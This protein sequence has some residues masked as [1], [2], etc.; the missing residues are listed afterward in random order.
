MAN[1]ED[2]TIVL[3]EDDP[4]HAYLIQKNLR[5]ANITNQ[6]VLIEDGQTAVDYL[7]EKNP[8]P[9]AALSPVLMLL[10]LN[11]PVLDGYEV[12]Q[13]IKTDDR[14]RHIPVIILTTTDNRHEVTRCYKLGC[15]A[16]LTKP[17]DYPAFVEMIERLGELLGLMSV[18][19]REL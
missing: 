3:V 6:I 14:T 17:V 2:V 13:R 12:L 4:G 7:L 10:D 11:L 5:R 8:Y 19:L 16:Y 1:I 9:T 15:S 18:P